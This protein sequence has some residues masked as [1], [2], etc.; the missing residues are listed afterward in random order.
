[1]ATFM[2]TAI[3]RKVASFGRRANRVNR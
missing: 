2:I 1:M 3:T